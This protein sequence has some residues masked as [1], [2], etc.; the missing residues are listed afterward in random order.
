MAQNF[1]NQKK[2]IKISALFLCGLVACNF[3]WGTGI[4]SAD[5]NMKSVI[6]PYLRLSAETKFDV[7]DGTS[8]GFKPPA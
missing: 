4:C 2:C 6:C 5:D 3:L 1:C 8:L 7:P